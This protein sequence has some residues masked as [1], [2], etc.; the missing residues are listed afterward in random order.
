MI[1]FKFETTSKETHKPM[2]QIALH[3]Y[4]FIF[5]ASVICFK[6]FHFWGHGI[7]CDQQKYFLLHV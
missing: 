6:K 7:G 4:S 1:W 3:N 5:S 2:A